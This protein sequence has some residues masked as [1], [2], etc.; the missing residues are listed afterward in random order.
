MF[1]LEVF[2]ENFDP[3]C[4]CAQVE[5][6]IAETDSYPGSDE[7]VL[8]TKRARKKSSVAKRKS[9]VMPALLENVQAENVSEIDET[10]VSG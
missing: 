6:M 7:A 8:Q 4:L 1:V 5:L 10:D 9:T 2:C 3:G